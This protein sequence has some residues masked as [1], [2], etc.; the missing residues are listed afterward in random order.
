MN[1]LA[2]ALDEWFNGSLRGKEAEANQLRAEIASSRG[3]LAS[4]RTD[5]MLISPRRNGGSSSPS[6]RTLPTCRNNGG[7][8]AAVRLSADPPSPPV[9][10]PSATSSLDLDAIYREIKRR[11]AADTGVLAL[12][13]HQP[14]LCRGFESGER[15]R[16]SPCSSDLRYFIQSYV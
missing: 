13:R 15:Y 16:L 1:G 3:P 6:I 7:Y 14:E 10:P 9:A 5:P 11:A 12:L 2:R 4:M 8:S